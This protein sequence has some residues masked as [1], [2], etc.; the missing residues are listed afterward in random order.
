MEHRGALITPIGAMSLPESVS[1]SH[2]ILK[3]CFAAAGVLCMEAVSKVV[4]RSATSKRLTTWP[5][6]TE[7]PIQI[8]AEQRPARSRLA[9]TAW[10]HHSPL[11]LLFL[12]GCNHPSE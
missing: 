3:P 10:A 4:H 8:R 7:V 9:R 2:T 11:R 6:R 1:R 5:P 12:L